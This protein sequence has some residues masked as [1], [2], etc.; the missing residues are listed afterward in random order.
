MNRTDPSHLHELSSGLSFVCDFSQQTLHWI[1]VPSSAWVPTTPQSIS[2]ASS[3]WYS[4]SLSSPSSILY[5]YFTGDA[6]LSIT[7]Y[8]FKSRFAGWFPVLKSLTLNLSRPSLIVSPRANRWSFES[9]FLLCSGL[10][11]F[12]CWVC[13][14][15][16]LTTT[17]II[18]LPSLCWVSPFK[19]LLLSFTWLDAESFVTTNLPAEMRY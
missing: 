15:R 13:D 7:P 4:F 10:L 3:S 6:L 8:F 16:F 2:T 18:L 17:N 11:P 9:G 19:F 5:L 14:L 12:Y 1:S